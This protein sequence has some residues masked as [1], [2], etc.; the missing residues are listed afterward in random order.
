MHDSCAIIARRSVLGARGLIVLTYLLFFTFLVPVLEEHSEDVDVTPAHLEPL[1]VLLMVCVVV[2][3]I[4]S[5]ILIGVICRRRHAVDRHLVVLDDHDDSSSS[6][7]RTRLSPL[8]S[9]LLFSMTSD[10]EKVKSGFGPAYPEF[11]G[12]LL[13]AEEPVNRN[14]DPLGE[15]PAIDGTAMECQE[16]MGSQSKHLFYKGPTTVLPGP[17]RC[18]VDKLTQSISEYEIPLD[19]QWEMPR[20]RS[21]CVCTASCLFKRRS[22]NGNMLSEKNVYLLPNC[23]FCHFYPILRIDLIRNVYFSFTLFFLSGLVV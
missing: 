8:H 13:G 21:V 19:P 16:T 9:N 7:L 18:R 22:V 6:S 15:L 23:R 20:D 17:I 4:T 5:V 14:T 2:L 3:S 11:A 12:A 1:T 10:D